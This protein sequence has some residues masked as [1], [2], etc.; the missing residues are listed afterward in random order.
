MRN[1]FL[2]I[3]AC[4]ALLLPHAPYAVA[5]GPAS[6]DAWKIYSNVY[7][8]PHRIMEGK[9]RTFFYALQHIYRPEWSYLF[10]EPAGAVFVYDRHNSAAGFQPLVQLADLHRGM[11][12]FCNYNPVTDVLVTAYADGVVDIIDSDWNVTHIDALADRSLPVEKKINNITFDISGSDI[13]VSTGSGFVHIDGATK[14]VLEA[15]SF[16]M[17]FNSICKVGQRVVAIADN[18]IY[19]VEPGADLALKASF[20]T[21]GL[22]VGYNP[23]MLMP[24]DDNNVAFV[25]NGKTGYSNISILRYTDGRWRTVPVYDTAGNESLSS[26]IANEQ[27][28]NNLENSGVMTRDGYLFPSSKYV[29]HLSRTVPAGGTPAVTARP[30]PTGVRPVMAT[31]NGTDF[32]AVKSWAN[33]SRLKSSGADASAT[34][35]ETQTL[36]PEAPRASRNSHFTYSPAAGLLYSNGGYGNNFVSDLNDPLLLSAYR[37]GKWSDLSSIY[38]RPDFATGDLSAVYDKVASAYPTRDPLGIV[39]DPVF[40]DYVFLGSRWDGITVINVKNPKATAL[41]FASTNNTTASLPGFKAFP[42]KSN[43][44]TYCAAHPGGFDNDGTFWAFMEITHTTSPTQGRSTL[45]YWTAEQRRACLETGDISKAGEFGTI[46]LDINQQGNSVMKCL[47]LRHPN[48]ANKVVLSIAP[49]SLVY[50]LDHN[51][52]LD[53]TSDDELTLV[54]NTLVSAEGGSN[55]W[56]G[57]RDMVEDPNTGEVLVAHLAGIGVFNPSDKPLSSGFPGYELSYGSGLAQTS[58]SFFSTVRDLC[59]DT[60][61]RLWIATSSDG[62]YGISADRSH[63][64]AK[65]TT[66]NSPLPSD[67]IW[68]LGWDPESQR[69]F[70][71]TQNGIASVHVGAAGVAMELRHLVASPDTVSSD[72]PGTVAIYNVEPGTTLSVYD[73]NDR[74]VAT[75]PL[76]A[77]G[78]TYW[79]LLDSDG[80]HVPAGVYRILNPNDHTDRLLITVS[81]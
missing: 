24:L 78:I 49:N 74:P 61:G 56:N 62:F 18:L 28:A 10:D 29:Y 43:W 73:R 77:D 48:N 2:V 6:T 51:G 36:R 17:N 26:L 71:S 33:L 4:A 67:C 32:W 19:H 60:Y 52:T 1:I 31:Y 57:V 50:I 64:V 59:Y 55:T 54:G 65:Y 58:A 41:R 25:R 34:W 16:G 23:N 9:S 21:T 30:L 69:I 63:I 44:N 11:M 53:D 27:P 66:E 68:S 39:A 75:L 8:Y 37:N 42:Y 81:H 12:I 72:Y 47:P 80:H 35:S 15:P 38:N 46:I 45:H 20:K 40:T 3:A 22:S 14:K 70:A 13:W 79:D 76:P 7:A 5:A